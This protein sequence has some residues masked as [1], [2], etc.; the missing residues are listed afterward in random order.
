MEVFIYSVS[1]NRTQI[2]SLFVWLVGLFCFVEVF[3]VV[4]LGVLGFFFGFCLKSEAQ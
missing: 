1:L 3:V 4:V 2:I